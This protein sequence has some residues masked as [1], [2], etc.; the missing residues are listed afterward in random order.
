[1]KFRLLYIDPPWEY[2]TYSLKG[3]KHSPKYTLMD[4]DA[5][6]RLPIQSVMAKRCIVFAWVTD[7]FIWQAKE[8]FEDHWGLS[9]RTVGFYYIK[10][11]KDGSGF[12]MG[13]GFYTRANPEQCWI[14]S[15]GQPFPVQDKA[16]PR[17][18]VE[19]R[20]KPHSRKPDIIYDYIDRL[21][22]DLLKLELFATRTWPGYTSLGF[23][24]DG[25][26]IFD[27]L[28]ELAKER[29]LLKR[30]FLNSPEISRKKK[31]HK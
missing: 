18:V 9:F 19:P 2:K 25:K 6:R 8:L 22:P 16:V 3:R 14:L 12:P 11:T 30:R 24:I 20:N 4:I 15:K 31:E 13:N 27:T 21:Y 29:R 17:L 1:M 26:D 23:D 10:T 28:P 7:P 5:L